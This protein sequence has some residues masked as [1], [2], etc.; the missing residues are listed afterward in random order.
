M[1]G[2]DIGG[3]GG[4]VESSG[5]EGARRPLPPGLTE[6]V[7]DPAQQDDREHREEAALAAAEAGAGRVDDAPAEP[8]PEAILE[9]G[10]GLIP[11]H[12]AI[13]LPAEVAK[14]CV[15][16]LERQAEE[17]RE[18]ANSQQG[19]LR[20]IAETRAERLQKAAVTFRAM[21]LRDDLS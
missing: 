9:A 15:A 1:P 5:G 20:Q 6:T 21:L 2:A 18:I 13:Q 3:E 10:T 17:H 16:A 14:T 11:G 7:P 4:W 8:Q 19:K 12:V